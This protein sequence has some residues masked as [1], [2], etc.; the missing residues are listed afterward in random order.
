MMEEI[1]KCL[2]IHFLYPVHNFVHLN[3]VTPHSPLV[4]VVQHMVPT[5]VNQKFLEAHKQGMK[6]IAL[7]FTAPSAGFSQLGLL[8]MGWT[9]TTIIRT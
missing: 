1:E 7:P 9:T 8:W 6:V 4:H 2:P 5:A 3:H